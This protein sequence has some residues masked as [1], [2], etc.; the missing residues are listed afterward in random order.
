MESVLA[1]NQAFSTD[2][3]IAHCSLL[4]AYCLLLIAHGSVSSGRTAAFP[5]DLDLDLGWPV[6]RARVGIGEIGMLRRFRGYGLIVIADIPPK[7]NL[8]EKRRWG[9]GS[10]GKAVVRIS[11]DAGI[12]GK[13]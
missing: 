1:G 3:L 5:L 7:K 13:P 4:I 6:C 9:K 8:A 10:W 11:A 2:G 12:A